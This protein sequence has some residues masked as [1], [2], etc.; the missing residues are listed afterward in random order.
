[1]TSMKDN[2]S[3]EPKTPAPRGIRGTPTTVGT[4]T[5]TTL[6]MTAPKGTTTIGNHRYRTVITEEKNNTKALG[7]PIKIGMTYPRAIR[8]TARIMEITTTSATMETATVR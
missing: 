3:R 1:M 8:S 6:P 4:K 7:T 2:N 5:T